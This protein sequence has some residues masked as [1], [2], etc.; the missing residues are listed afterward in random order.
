MRAA[1][2]IWEATSPTSAN[3]D[4]LFEVSR[5]LAHAGVLFTRAGVAIVTWLALALWCAHA[6]SRLRSLGAEDMH[7]TP[8][9]AAVWWVIPIAHLWK[10]YQVVREIW[11]ASA[12]LTEDYQ[13]VGSVLLPVWWIAHLSA[14]ITGRVGARL[15]IA[16][17]RAPAPAN[18]HEV[19]SA[20]SAL[21]AVSAV[22]ASIC[23]VL[24]VVQV[25]A[26][27]RRASMAH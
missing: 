17:D 27:Q 23:C 10:P 20:L 9:F 2:A 25:T 14:T 4:S 16:A 19:A 3:P 21:G 6:N 11:K 5:I 22:L 1:F 8:V 18:T 24:I 13:S 7:Q 26:R 15:E 12:L